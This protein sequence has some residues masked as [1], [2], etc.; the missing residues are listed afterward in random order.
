M[1]TYLSDIPKATDSP[2]TSQ[3]QLLNNFAYVSA[4]MGKDHNFTANSA[5]LTDGFHKQVTFAS[6]QAAPGF[7][8]GVSDL[9]SNTTAGVASL[10]WQNAS[11]SFPITG[12][13]PSVVAN[14]YTCLPGGILIQWGIKTGVAS[15][16]TLTWPVAFTAL[17][18]VTLTPITGTAN[19][20]FC[21]VGTAPLTTEPTNTACKVRILDSSGSDT[22]GSFYYMAIG[23]KV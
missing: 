22:T 11:G 2:S 3:G 21:I 18:S 14:G 16:Y 6:N 20:V 10:Q 1:P 4:S 8:A 19:R 5:N 23:T 13:N 7:G 17:F 12:L 9:F 15:I